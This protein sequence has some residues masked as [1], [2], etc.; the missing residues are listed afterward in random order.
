MNVVAF[1][2]N[3]TRD[4]EVRYLPNGT[5]VA[6]FGIAINESFKKKGSD[7]WEKKTNFFEIE[8]FAALGERCGKFVKGDKVSVVGQARQDTWE[9]DGQ[10]RSKIVFR[11][12]QISLLKSKND[13]SDT[14]S[15]D[16]SS[17]TSAELQDIPF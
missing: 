12:N 17:D 10:K 8:A 15:G 6:N 11:A 14:G 13:A 5:A 3:I 9:T 2:G 7:E 16:S 1:I 4:P